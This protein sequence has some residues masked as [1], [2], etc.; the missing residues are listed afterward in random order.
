MYV[1]YYNIN[2]LPFA[3]SP[4]PHVCFVV[5]T[6]V[7]NMHKTDLSVFVVDHDVVW[8]DI[9]VHNAHAVAVVQ[10]LYGDSTGG[11]VSLTCTNYQHLRY[12]G[13]VVRIKLIGHNIYRQP[14]YVTC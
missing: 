10:G 7:Q 2:N 3:A 12:T 5:S 6:K 13:L 1:A 9:P 8:F 11:T 4:H 14:T